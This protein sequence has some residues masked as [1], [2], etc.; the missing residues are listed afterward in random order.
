MRVRPFQ[1]LAALPLQPTPACT[2]ARAPIHTRSLDYWRR[3]LSDGDVA[4]ILA[5]A[6]DLQTRIQTEVAGGVEV[7]R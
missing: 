6:G 3:C 5:V 7:S 4:E 1:P 2:D